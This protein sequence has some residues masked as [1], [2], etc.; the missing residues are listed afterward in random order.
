MLINTM[1][2][3]P[4][5]QLIQHPSAATAAMDV[6]AKSG[7]DTSSPPP[8]TAGHPGMAPPPP[9]LMA[10]PPP[11]GAALLQH[12]YLRAVPPLLPAHL[13]A[14]TQP[15]PLGNLHIPTSGG[16]K[17]MDMDMDKDDDAVKLFVGQIPR[18]LEDHNLRPM[19]EQ[20]GKI[21]EFTVLKDKLTGMHKGCAFLT[22][23]TREAA[24]ACQ[25]AL[26]EQ[27]TL[28]GMNRPLQ[29]KPADNESNRGE[30]RKLF[31]GMLSKQQTEEEVR[32]IFKAYGPI[33][34][35]TI[36]RGPDGNSKGCAFVKLST[37]D[38]AQS[39]IQGL[40]GCRT[41]PGASSSLVVKLADTEKERQIRRMQQ[42]ATNIGLLNPF[43]LPAAA[44]AALGGPPP[45]PYGPGGIM[46]MSGPGGIPISQAY[47]IAGVPITCSSATDPIFSM[48]GAGLAD[49][50][51][52]TAAGF[53]AHLAAAYHGQMGM[54][55]Y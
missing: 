21:Y 29:V 55:W 46:P 15:P 42:M 33:E 45:S 44:A 31:V 18:N 37:T 52:L 26:H 49:H 32:D 30:D 34:E 48:A 39:A 16:G 5:P 17:L 53:P 6:S 25:K 10:G 41:M 27:I 50:A 22:Y 40:H 51:G 20:F 36:L 1:Y 43:L 47:S 7:G 12:P 38:A 9:G 8:P 11:P 13:M 24:E 19:F 54:A 23:C 4:R 35:C 2:M 14:A 28:P 3:M